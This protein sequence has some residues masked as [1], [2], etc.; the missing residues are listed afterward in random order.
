MA[1]ALK[2]SIAALFVLSYVAIN[3]AGWDVVP[4]CPSG[5][6]G[7]IEYPP[8]CK[9]FVRCSNGMGTVASCLPGRVFNPEKKNCDWHLNVPDCQ[10]GGFLDIRLSE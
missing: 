4:T 9:L 8:N 6:S 7:K 1:L 3:S 5:W 10:D 2:M